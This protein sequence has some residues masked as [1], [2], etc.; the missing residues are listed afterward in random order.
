LNEGRWKVAIQCQ[1]IFRIREYADG[2][3]FVAT[4]FHTVLWEYS[5]LGASKAI[6][7]QTRRIRAL[8]ILEDVKYLQL[9]MTCSGALSTTSTMAQGSAAPSEVITETVSTLIAV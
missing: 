1:Q 6:P 9:L 8:M 4:Q 2:I 7:L 3:Q 5:E